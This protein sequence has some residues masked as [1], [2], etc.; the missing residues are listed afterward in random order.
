MSNA[1]FTAVVIAGLVLIV[2]GLSVFTV[3][4][5]ELAIK[6]QFGEVVEANHEPGLH[7]K[8]PVLQNVRKFPKRIL[9]I[10][11]KPERIF[12]AERL[13]LQ[14]DFFVKWRIIDAVQFYTSTGGNLVVAND[15]LS[16]IIKNAIVTEFG[17]RSV[18]EAISVERAE[19]MR[20]MLEN[21]K[22]TAQGLGVEL[23]DVRVKQVEFP[24]D[25]RNSV[26]QQ[27]REERARVAAERR[28]EGREIS[29][30]MRSTADK[31]RTII[32]A[33]AYRDSQKL[34]G[35]GD[36][37]ASEI[38]ANA[39]NKDPEFYAFYR[40]IDAYRKSMGRS[41]D[42]LILDPENEFFR[43]LNQSDGKR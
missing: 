6:L 22:D 19:L 16:E 41:G 24:D 34:R 38:Y 17:K 30:Q 9:T 43:Y 33:D 8:L 7:L 42:I 2:G 5:R 32:L 39:Y 1:R 12:T 18:Q 3:N 35:E 20:D 26:Y 21:A 14:V 36:A 25:V 11:D 13:A 10:S 31:E 28:A 4:E 40:S 37:T 23:I 29:E 15:R 27:M